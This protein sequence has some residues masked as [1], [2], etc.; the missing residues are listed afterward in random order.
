M[1]VPY[2]ISILVIDEIPLI[3]VGLQEVFRTIHPAIRVE[4]TDSV[5]KALSSREYENKSF[6]LV[7]L[8]SDEEKSS[9]SLLL[10]ATELRKRFGQPLIMIYSSA[11]DPVIIEKMSTT[12]IDAYVHKYESIQ[13]ILRAYEQ[14]SKGEPYVSSIFHTLYY[15]YGH[16]VRK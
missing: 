13:E 5:F 2:L 4:Y 9:E 3:P 1:Q 16:S 14:L 11:Y 6:H 10:H 12:G 8:G 7:I 15:Q